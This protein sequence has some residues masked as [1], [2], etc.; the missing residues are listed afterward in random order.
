MVHHSQ[1]EGRLPFH[2]LPQ[3]NRHGNQRLSNFKFYKFYSSKSSKFKEYKLKCPQTLAFDMIN[4]RSDLVLVKVVS[5]EFNRLH[6]K[7]EC[8]LSVGQRHTVERQFTPKK[9]SFVFIQPL[10]V[11]QFSR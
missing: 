3:L 1:V 4:E 6:Q 5:K 2:Q 7:L 11:A 9:P 8:V 10:S